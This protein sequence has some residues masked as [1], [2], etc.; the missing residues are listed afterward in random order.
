MIIT[1]VAIIAI[2]R[3]AALTYEMLVVPFLPNVS[4]WLVAGVYFAISLALSISKSKIVDIVGK[5]LTPLLL[6]GLLTLIIGGIVNPIGSIND[7]SRSENIIKDGLENG[8]QAMDIFGALVF[9]AIVI[10]AAEAK[11]YRTTKEKV[12]VCS[13]ASV[14]AVFGLVVI[15]VGL[16]Y[17]GA[18]ASATLD[19]TLEQGPLL[20]AITETIL[21]RTGVFLVGLVTSL[22]CLTTT[23]GLGSALADLYEEGAHG[24][25]DYKVIITIISVVCAFVTNVG[26]SQIIAIASPILSLTYP[27]CIVLV[28]FTYTDKLLAYNRNIA[29]GAFITLL[30]LGIFNLLD[31]YGVSIG[32]LHYLPFHSSGLNW[33]IPAIIGSVIGAFVKT[34]DSKYYADMN[35]YTATK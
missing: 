33:V 15:Y 20:V 26:L 21:G 32:F 11:G 12:R 17:L 28:L 2:P 22:A 8:Y 5:V 16:G 18:T 24:K 14:I 3:Q 10:A 34:S 7:F 23:I 25:V 13:M 29:R 1:A 27:I 35:F 4:L 30:I 6:I 31:G 9:P 19:P